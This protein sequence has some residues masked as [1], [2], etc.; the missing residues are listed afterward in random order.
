MGK[1]D[2]KMRV[3]KLFL[4]F[5]IFLTTCFRFYCINQYDIQLNKVEEQNSLQKPKINFVMYFTDAVQTHS[6]FAYKINEA[7]ARF[8]NLS[9]VLVEENDDNNFDVEDVRWNK[10]K[11]LLN[12]LNDPAESDVDYWIWLDSDLV[13]VNFTFNISNLIKQYENFEI[14]LSREINP[15]NGV[16][17]TGSIIVKNSEWSQKFFQSWWYDFDHVSAMDQHSFEELHSKFA[18]IPPVNRILLLPETAINS[19]FPGLWKHRDDLPILHLAGES[20]FIRA[21]ILQR[22]WE[23][24]LDRFDAT[25]PL[26]TRAE[27]DSIDYFLAHLNEWRLIASDLRR[28][29]SSSHDFNVERL[30]MVRY[31]LCS[32]SHNFV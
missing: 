24:Y 17:N 14:I 1:E 4:R 5:L 21:I 12:L 30:Q 16:A 13:F 23:N 2:S 10:V 11:I 31:T 28:Q 20:N 19:E 15:A 6:T 22:I 3:F 8:M 26:I 7:Y 9:I 29:S 32:F 27:L 25:K 18:N